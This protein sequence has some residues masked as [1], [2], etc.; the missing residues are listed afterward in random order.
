VSTFKL[1]DI[2]PAPTTDLSILLRKLLEDRDLTVVQPLLDELEG[3]GR[4]K[5]LEFVRQALGDT[6][7]HMAQGTQFPVDGNVIF[8]TKITRE[9][10]PWFW[11][12]LFD[13]GASLRA[14]QK[15]LDAALVHTATRPGER[16]EF[17]DLNA[18]RS[19]VVYGPNT[20]STRER[21]P[22]EHQRWLQEQLTRFAA[23]P[24]GTEPPVEIR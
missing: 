21:T 17:P 18:V 2:D 23:W 20:G 24:E 16:P 9:L 4:T 13:T 7:W 15:S 3:L 6:F 5:D 22:E 1:P 14:L 8:H 10:I 19:G 11:F 12:D